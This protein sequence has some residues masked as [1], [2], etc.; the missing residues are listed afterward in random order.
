MLIECRVCKREISD[1]ASSCP[2]CGHPIKVESPEKRQNAP[3]FLSLSVVAFF[4]LFSTPRLLLFFPLMGTIGCAV[5]S[6]LRKEKGRGGA[7]AVLCLGIGI[8]VLSDVGSHTSP[9][10]GGLSSSAANLDAAEISDFNWSKDAEFGT[11]GTIKWNV[12]IGNKS[13]QNIEAAKVQFETYDEAGKLVSTN[14]TYVDAIPTGQTRST[15]SYAD[16]YGTE[17]TANAQI[18]EIRYAH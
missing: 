15:E 1:Q 12:K 17:R 5:I 16:L 13:S 9:P 10:V 2:N 4:L 14:F 11:K 7:V 3:I 6:M 8:W 18:V